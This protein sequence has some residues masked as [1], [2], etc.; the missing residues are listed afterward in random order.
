MKIFAQVISWV[1]MPLFMPIYALLLVMFVPS[2]QDFLFN[3]DNLFLQPLQFKTALLTMFGIFCVLAPGISFLILQRYKLISSVEMETKKERTVPII[4]MMLY[5]LALYVI[6]VQI[7]KGLIVPKFI[8]AL[9]LSGAVVTAIFLIVNRWKKISIH[10]GAAGIVTGF[11]LAYVLTQTEYQLWVFTVT[12]L[13]A[14]LV[15]S[16]RLYLQRHTISELIIGWM[17]GS[18]ITFGINYFY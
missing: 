17:I 9:P 6:L 4:V 8:F 2:N 15:M 13:V 1:F 7:T 11:V 18:F 12:I 10:S 16:A 5:C 3:S 14:G